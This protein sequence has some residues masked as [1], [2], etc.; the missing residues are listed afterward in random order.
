MFSGERKMISYQKRAG[1]VI[2]THDRMHE[3]KQYDIFA[4][5]LEFL[6]QY[7]YLS[8]ISFPLQYKNAVN[9]GLT[10]FL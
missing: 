9:R 10:T 4:K 5:A 7:N 1:D 8:T 6:M 2:D 3:N